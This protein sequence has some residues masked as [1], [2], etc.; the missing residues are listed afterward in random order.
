MQVS[1]LAVSFALVASLAAASSAFAAAP[2][3]SAPAQGCT[4]AQVAQAMNAPLTRAEVRQQ[5]IEAEH[6]GQLAALQDLYR[7]G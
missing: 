6:D 4:A 1:K 5:L 2:A 3:Q 7:G